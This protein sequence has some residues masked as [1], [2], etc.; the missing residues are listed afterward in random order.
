MSL[1]TILETL[2]IGPLKLVFEI[3]FTLANRFVGHPGLAIIFLSLIMNILVLPLYRRADAMQEESR[4]IDMKLEKGVTHIKKHFSGDERMMI[5]QTYYRQNNYKPT[6]ALNGSVSLLLEVPFFMAAYQFLSQL[7]ILNGVPFGPIADLGAPDGLIVIGGIAINFLPILMT[8]INVISSALYLKGFP[9]KTK[10]QLYAMAAFFLVFLYESPSCLVFYW[11]LNNVFS[12]VKT[13]F[14]KLKNPQKV[15]RDLMAVAGLGLLI[16]VCFFY[17]SGSAKRKLFLVAVGAALLLP[18]VLTLVK[19]KMPVRKK[20]TDVLPN[21]TMFLLGALLLTILVGLLIPS[22]F[23]AASPQEYVD[24]SFFHNPMWYIVSALCLAAGTFIVWMSVFYWLASTKGKVVFDRLVWI[25]CGVMLVNYMFFGT[26]L[27]IITST[28]QYE[29]GMAFGIR[30]ELFNLAVISIVAAAMYWISVKYPKAVVAVLLTVSIALG[31]MSALNIFTVQDS[32]DSI[33][34]ENLETPNFQ[35]SKTGKN[36]IVLMLDRAVGEYV[37]YILNE[38]PELQK[39]FEGFTYYSNVIS[40]GGKTNFGTPP[41]FGGYE[42]TP[43]EINKRNTE[44]M[45]TKHNEAVKVMPVL[46]L[47]NGFDVTVCDPSH[48]NYQQ[49]PDL[50]IFDEYP[51]IDAYITKG[52]FSDPTSK[53]QAIENNYRNFFCFGIMKSMPLVMQPAIYDGGAY[54]Q[55]AASASDETVIYSNQTTDGISKGEGISKLFMDPYNVLQNLSYMTNV[56]EDETNTFLFMINETPHG[57]ALLQTPDYTPSYYVDNTQYDAENTDRFTVGDK[58]I[59]MT[60]EMQMT[61]YHANMASL[62][63]V[64][65]WLDYLRANDVYDNTKIILVSDHASPLYHYEELDH[66]GTSWV[67]NVEYYYP[68]LMVKDFGSK[69]FKVSTEFM[70]NA[71]VATLATQGVIENPINPFTGKLI[72]MDEKYAHDQFIIMSEKWQIEEN[73]G[74][75]YLPSK[76]ASVSDDIWVK[77]NW[78][79]IEENI[80]LDKHEMP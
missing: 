80:V 16:F 18:T 19:P 55:A 40:F 46:F 27:G 69:E 12:L 11:T 45:V 66:G 59:E 51:E 4:N 70:T 15:L 72:N 61:H 29:E 14:Y 62:L 42:Y 2:L 26:N 30:E 8:L 54:N 35:L 48:A 60:T 76:W 20:T 39:Q 47:Q 58:S 68:L 25:L 75:T 34:V 32:I 28:L 38:K 65:R 64:G 43:V 5:L 53:E 1:I 50:S 36:V 67:Y 13:I 49:I 78:S 74:Y 9:L 6:D 52:V 37:P 17:Y 33:S 79:F 3:I 41:L 10:I 31:G 71:D 57:P 21:R 73:N 23:I 56:T 24:V 63:E 22:T 7:E 77:D 44:D